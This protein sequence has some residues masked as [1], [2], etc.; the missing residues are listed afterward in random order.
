MTLKHMFEKGYLG[1]PNVTGT[2][3]KNALW[4]WG[5]CSRM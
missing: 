5:N 4:S 2:K 3:E 1:R